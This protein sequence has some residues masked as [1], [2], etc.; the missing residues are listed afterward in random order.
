MIHASPCLHFRTHPPA[1]SYVHSLWVL[2]FARP[3]LHVTS[4]GGVCCMGKTA[5]R[6]EVLTDPTGL[7][8]T[9]LSAQAFSAKRVHSQL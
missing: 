3:E 8:A 5:Q 1:L 6:T 7:S 4:A 2:A 9:H